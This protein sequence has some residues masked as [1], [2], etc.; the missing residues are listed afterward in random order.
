M[1]EGYFFK[2]S[3]FTAIGSSGVK[4]VAYRHRRHNKHCKGDEHFMAIDIDDL[5]RP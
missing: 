4:T 1:N 5:E 3:Y 2:S